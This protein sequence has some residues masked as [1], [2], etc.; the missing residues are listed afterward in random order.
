MSQENVEIRARVPPEIEKRGVPPDVPR[1][2]V[3]GRNGR[4]FLDYDTNQIMDQHMGLVRF[5]SDAARALASSCWRSASRG[6]PNGRLTTSS[7]SCQMRLRCSPMT[8]PRP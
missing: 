4:L 8:F 2:V 1:K 6:S 3:A 5:T 7:W